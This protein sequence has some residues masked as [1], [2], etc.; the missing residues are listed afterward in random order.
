MESKYVLEQVFS[1][2]WH[3]K[4]K[5]HTVAH[6]EGIDKTNAKGQVVYKGI[7]KKTPEQV[8]VVT[9][10]P[11]VPHVHFNTVNMAAQHAIKHIDS[12]A[13]LGI[14]HPVHKI[15]KRMANL[16]RAIQSAASDHRTT[17]AQQDGILELSKSHAQT[18]KSFKKHF[19]D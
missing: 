3:L 4:N 6:I 18:K 16:D 19:G 12:G 1:S 11:G 15:K 10:L 5:D 13:H 9:N 7:F 8:Y 2:T 14:F 17:D